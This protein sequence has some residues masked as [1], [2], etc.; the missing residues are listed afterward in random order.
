MKEMRL[1][2]PDPFFRHG[3][4]GYG[5]TDLRGP[6]RIVAPPLTVHAY[7]RT[8]PFNISAV[9]RL[10]DCLPRKVKIAPVVSDVHDSFFYEPIADA[11]IDRL[12]N[13][14]AIRKGSCSA[15]WRRLD[16]KKVDLSGPCV[17]VGYRVVQGDMLV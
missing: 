6:Q 12:I 5:L 15:Y 8:V 11:L 4:D 3:M 7:L 1:V 2:E 10:K 16:T 9:R 17:R 13:F 14:T